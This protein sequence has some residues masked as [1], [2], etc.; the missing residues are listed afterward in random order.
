[1]RY[2]LLTINYTKSQLTEECFILCRT[3]IDISVLYYII[4]Y[5]FNINNC[6]HFILYY[7][8]I[9]STISLK[10]HI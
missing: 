3:I 9:P 8:Y 5:V 1:M 7:T 2:R 6:L 4:F 10:M